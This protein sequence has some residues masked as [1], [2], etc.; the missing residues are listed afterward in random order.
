MRRRALAIV[1][2]VMAAGWAEAQTV[3]ARALPFKRALI[4]NVH[5]VW[6]LDGPVAAMAAQVHQESGWRVDARSSHAAGLAQ[7]TPPTAT[8]MARWY[9]AELGEGGP[10]NPSWALRALVRYDLRLYLLEPRAAN[11]CERLAFTLS[12]YNGGRGWV[13]KQ[14]AAA[15]RAGDDQARWFGHVERHRVR[16]PAAHLENVHYPRRIL[17]ALQPVYRGWGPSV[18]CEGVS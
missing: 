6:G 18:S 14:K 11:A 16:A 3:P 7:F 13:I 12:A 8:D 5:L 1:V 4:Q 2:L 10:L 15:A 17:L 9:P